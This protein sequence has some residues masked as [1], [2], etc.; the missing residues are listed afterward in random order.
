LSEIDGANHEAV[1]DQQ[2]AT[3]PREHHGH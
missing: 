1:T 3:L 2:H